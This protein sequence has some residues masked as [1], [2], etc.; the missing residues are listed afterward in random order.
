MGRKQQENERSGRPIAEKQVRSD[1][2]SKSEHHEQLREDL[3]NIGCEEFL[4]V[5]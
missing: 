5:P 3:R 4:K 2:S 1:I